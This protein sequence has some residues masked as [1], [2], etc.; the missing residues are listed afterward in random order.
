MIEVS[1]STTVTIEHEGVITLPARLRRRLPAGARFSVRYDNGSIILDPQP[2][3]TRE[4]AFARLD[5]V[6]ERI[7]RHF[8]ERGITVADI[9]RTVKQ[10]RA[11]QRAKGSLPNH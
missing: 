9:R 1:K 6:T 3:Q 4:E 5:A 10:V 7:A 11:E 2:P 8:D